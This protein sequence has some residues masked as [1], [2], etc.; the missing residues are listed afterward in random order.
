M[1]EK[2][3]IHLHKIIHVNV[4]FYFTFK[5]Q[6]FNI[7]TVERMNGQ[8]RVRLEKRHWVR[9][10]TSPRDMPGVLEFSSFAIAFQFRQYR[11]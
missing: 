2:R 4:D 8:Y 9:L 11:R 3:G 1:L 7:W 6:L 10:Y 5:I